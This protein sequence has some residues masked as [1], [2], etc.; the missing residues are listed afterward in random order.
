MKADYST[1]SDDPFYTK[2]VH[3]GADIEQAKAVGAHAARNLQS[4]FDDLIRSAEEQRSELTE[5][6]RR[7]ANAERHL[8]ATLLTLQDQAEKIR[9]H[10]NHQMVL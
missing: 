3:T 6:H 5:L 8:K 10:V 1:L 7:V 9:A 4:D 2:K